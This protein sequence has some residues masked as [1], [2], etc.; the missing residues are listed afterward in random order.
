MK[1]MLIK[2]GI[3]IFISWLKGQKQGDL[4]MSPLVNGLIDSQ[5]VDDLIDTIKDDVTEE[6][7][8]E[9]VADIAEEPAGNLL[10][11]IFGWLF[12]K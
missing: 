2:I 5:T 4:P 11:S 3:Q 12:K 7:I 1:A 9:I 6:V 10:D 8:T